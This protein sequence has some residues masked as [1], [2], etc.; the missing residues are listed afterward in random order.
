MPDPT[1]IDPALALIHEGWDHLQHQRPLAA[2]A[3]W[4]RALRVSPEHPAALK[5]LEVLAGA[6]DLPMAARSEYRFLT[7]LGDAQRSRWDAR[8]RGQNLEELAVAAGAFA[9][10]ADDD[11]ADGRA[12]F[13]QG[14][15]LA[16]L[17]RN[18]EAVDALD[19]A[20]QAL[21]FD[22]PGVAIDAWTLAEVL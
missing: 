18:L 21:A 3:S 22:E 16:W 1:P 9:T 5:A 8:F 14:L 4:R 15:C 12:R 19:R 10:L 20:V 7:P 11:P 13:N 6:G 17:G 2:W